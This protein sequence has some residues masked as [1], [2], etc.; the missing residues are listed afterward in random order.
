MSS[1]T[2]QNF[3]DT[4]NP[5]PASQDELS[6]ALRSLAITSEFAHGVI[7]KAAEKEYKRREQA[8][9]HRL[10]EQRSN[11]FIAPTHGVPASVI[12]AEL[13]KLK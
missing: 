1:T 6:K 4:V 2:S 9:L 3:D 12:E 8:L 13:E 5:T 7:H 10:L 11:T